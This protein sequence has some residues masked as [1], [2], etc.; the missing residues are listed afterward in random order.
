MLRDIF[1]SEIIDFQ[2]ASNVLVNATN[3]AWFGRSIASAQHFQMSRMRAIETGRYL[4]RSTNTGITAIVKPDG[5][6]QQQLKPFEYSVLKDVF[7]TLNH[8]VK[9]N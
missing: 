2:P 4:L 6:V 7:V 5:K 3:N 1:G 9:P 8:F